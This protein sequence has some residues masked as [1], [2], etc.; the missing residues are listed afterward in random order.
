MDQSQKNVKLSGTSK[1][2]T[3]PI[4]KS[5]TAPLPNTMPDPVPLGARRIW[6]KV[7]P[8]K[9]PESTIRTFS[10]GGE[11]KYNI[12]P[13]FAKGV[14]NNEMTRKGYTGPDARPGITRGG[15]G[16]VGSAGAYPAEAHSSYD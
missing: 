9:A 15:S 1:P 3:P 12:K 6:N 10:D 5:K 11:K 7:R 4:T 14:P 2:T 13:K 8:H 16:D